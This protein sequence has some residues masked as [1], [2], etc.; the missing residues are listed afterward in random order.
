M[1]LHPE[2]NAAIRK[3]LDGARMDFLFLFFILPS[4]LANKQKL[5]TINPSAS[6]LHLS[7]AAVPAEVGRFFSKVE[8]FSR[9][10]FFSTIIAFTLRSVFIGS[11]G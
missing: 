4:F 9:S 7:S 3:R 1:S 8:R 11:P 2:I 10:C 5:P 6:L